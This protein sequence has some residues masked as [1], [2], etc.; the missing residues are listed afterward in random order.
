MAGSVGSKA[1]R[2]RKRTRGCSLRA[3]ATGIVLLGAISA[4]VA[5]SYQF[6]ITYLGE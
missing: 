2:T 1:S 4:A 3:A 6:M 5:I